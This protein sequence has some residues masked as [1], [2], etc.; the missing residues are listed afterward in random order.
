MAISGAYNGQLFGLLVGFGAGTIKKVVQTGKG[1]EFPLFKAGRLTNNFIG[2]LV[3]FTS[4]FVLMFTWIWSYR[5][6]F[7]MTKTFARIMVSIY[8][9]FVACATYF[10]FGKNFLAE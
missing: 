9:T 2:L 5:N 7:N 1:S 10:T 3:I 8:V 4:L 6:R